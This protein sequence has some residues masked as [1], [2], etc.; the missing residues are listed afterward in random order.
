MTVIVELMYCSG[1]AT[2]IQVKTFAYSKIVQIKP[3]FNRHL[4]DLLESF[5]L[6]VDYENIGP[7]T[8]SYYQISND[9]KHLSGICPCPKQESLNHWVHVDSEGKT[10]LRSSALVGVL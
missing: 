8:C 10:I 3:K 2:I 6:K 4:T 1:T 5:K 7:N 9:S